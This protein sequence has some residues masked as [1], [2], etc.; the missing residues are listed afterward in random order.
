M[1]SIE[2]RRKTTRRCT[3]AAPVAQR[4]RPHSLRYALPQTRGERAKNG[5]QA[6]MRQIVVEDD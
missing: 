2:S 5:A 6:R 3:P 4:V 1:R